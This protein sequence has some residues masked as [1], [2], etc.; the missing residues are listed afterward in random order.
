MNRF[1]RAWFGI[2]WWAACLCLPAAV[3]AQAGAPEVTFQ[4]NDSMVKG[5]VLS[6]VHVEVTPAGGTGTVASGVTDAAGQY[7]VVLPA[8]KYQVAF[9]KAG[10]VYIA[11]TEVEVGEAAQTVT[12]TMTM[13]MEAV[14][15]VEK[16][17]IQIV[18]NWGEADDQPK[19]LDS[20]LTCPCVPEGAHVYYSAKTHAPESHSA[21]LDVDDIDGGGPETITLIDPPPGSYR[22]WVHNY[23]SS[24]PYLGKAG[25]VV[26]V[27]FGDTVA[28][29]FRMP[30]SV[31]ARVWLPFKALLVDEGLIPK[32]ERFTDE[33]I[34]AQLAVQTPPQQT[35]GTEPTGSGGGEGEVLT[36]VFVGVGAVLVLAAMR[37]VRG[38]RAGPA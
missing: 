31:T 15:L 24:A 4:V 32:I 27:I 1:P 28:G 11:G 29:E 34:A 10:Y 18:L 17:R 9:A 5:K 7:K 23:S 20:H 22:Y 25:A 35:Y 33:E 6:G 14:G 21:A 8:G 3:G 19:D 36:L 16:R 26:R 37:R 13:M 2:L 30:A 12:T 38:R